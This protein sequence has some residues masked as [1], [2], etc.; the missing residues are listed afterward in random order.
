MG[1]I[2]ANIQLA[3]PLLKRGGAM[4]GWCAE[5]RTSWKPST[6]SRLGGSSSNV[7]GRGRAGGEST[8]GDVSDVTEP[9]EW[10]GDS[11]GVLKGGAAEP[12]DPG[13]CGA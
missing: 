13:S 7:D 4:G 11:S 2:S 3:T 1:L 9:K 8:R 5:E 10:R 12:F 6:S